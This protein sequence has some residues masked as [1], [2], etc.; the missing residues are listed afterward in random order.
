[1]SSTGLASLALTACL[2]CFGECGSAYA[3]VAI[4]RAAPSLVLTE[5]NGDTFDLSQKRGKV[6]LLNYWATWCAPAKRKCPSSTPSTA[7]ITGEGW[8]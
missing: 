3:E 4:D 1:M 6:V 5:L 7:V 2:L 8:K